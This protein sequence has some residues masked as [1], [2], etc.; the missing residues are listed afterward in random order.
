MPFLTSS[1]DGATPRADAAAIDQRKR[2]MLVAAGAVLATAPFS[3]LQAA[4][5]NAAAGA[6]TQAISKEHKME[7]NRYIGPG[8]M[9]I[10]ESGTGPR[11]VFVHGGGA[12]G[13]MAWKEQAP[14]AA[15][16]RLIMPARPGYGDS[17]WPGSEDFARDADLIA[18][19]IKPGDH[20]VAHSYGAA[21]A[22]LAVAKDVSKPASLTIIESGTSDIAKDDPA[23]TAFHYAALGLAAHPP[24]DDEEF[25]R[26][27]FRIIQPA[28]A[29]PPQL[30]PPLKAFAA[31]LRHFRSPAEAIVPEQILRAA[32]FRKLHVSGDHNPAYEGITRRL[33][34][35]LGGE[36]LVIRGGGH[37]PQRT[38]EPFN[39]ALNKFLLG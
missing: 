28:Q 7:Q 6:P 1:T 30:P 13:A 33:A 24:A 27:L 15:N 34:A 16:W 4:G 23:V 39:Q 11:V 22:L 21:V 36:H 9:V 35:R 5:N 8:G 32:S 17:P 31:H 14:L 29:L 37:T 12:G 2:S 38:G 26:A 10:D 20:V 25:L 18:E 3:K 19:L